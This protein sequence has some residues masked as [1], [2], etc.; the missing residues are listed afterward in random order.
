MPLSSS[1]WAA[2]DAQYRSYSVMYSVATETRARP[3]ATSVDE[4]KMTRLLIGFE[5][6]SFR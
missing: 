5:N 2:H 6:C 4:M 3:R 1:S